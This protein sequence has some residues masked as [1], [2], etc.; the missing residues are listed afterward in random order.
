MGSPAGR[1]GGPQAPF[2]GSGGG[3]LVSHGLGGGAFLGGSL[4]DEGGGGGRLGDFFLPLLLSNSENRINPHYNCTILLTLLLL[5]K[6]ASQT[7]LMT[8]C[9]I[10]WKTFAGR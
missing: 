6:M 4:D 9:L 1:E 10:H 8:P 7:T 3:G 2:L 5:T